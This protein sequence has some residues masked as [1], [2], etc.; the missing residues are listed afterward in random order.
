MQIN[1]SV[2]EVR[3]FSRRYKE[4]GRRAAARIGRSPTRVTE[5]C[6][7]SR[8]HHAT[9]VAGRGGVEVR[10]TNPPSLQ[11]EH[12]GGS[13]GML[14]GCV[15]C[16]HGSASHSCASSTSRGFMANRKRCLALRVPESIPDVGCPRDAHRGENP[17]R[18]ES[19]SK[20]HDPAVVQVRQ[21]VP[22]D[23]WKVRRD[24]SRPRPGSVDVGPLQSSSV[25][26]PH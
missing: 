1:L 18:L 20:L 3:E 7:P 12:P 8:P 9:T 22:G 10:Q 15:R 13:Q 25:T 6:S 2:E 21:V 16:S 4:E 17:P 5:G 19:A 23:R 11:E 14:C 24:T 26:L